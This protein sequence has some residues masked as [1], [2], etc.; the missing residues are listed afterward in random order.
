M[1]SAMDLTWIDQSI[2]AKSDV[3]KADLRLSLLTAST[4]I[5]ALQAGQ[6]DRAP[7]LHTHATSDVADLE[8][9]LA[10]RVRL[11]GGEAANLLLKGATQLGLG[12][13]TLTAGVLTLDLTDGAI[14]AQQ[15]TSNVTSIAI[16]N[17][18]A[19]TGALSIKLILAQDNAGSRTVTWPANWQGIG[20]DAVTQ[21]ATAGN[22]R[23]IYEVWSYDNGGT[24][25]VERQVT[26]F[27][28][29]SPPVTTLDGD[30]AYGGLW[31]GNAFGG[32]GA[33]GNKTV[34]YSSTGWGFVAATI[35]VY[36]TGN[37]THIRVNNRTDRAGESGYGNGQCT[38]WLEI[39][40]ALADG[41]PD[42]TSGGLLG[43]TNNYTPET[44]NGPHLSDANFHPKLAFQANVPVTAGAKICVVWKGSTT[45]NS[46]FYSAN[47]LI[48]DKPITPRAGPAWGDCKVWTSSNGGDTWSEAK[49]GGDT[50][51]SRG[52]YCF[53]GDFFYSDGIVHG[54][55][56]RYVNSSAATY[57]PLIDGGSFVRQRFQM[58]ANSFTTK[59]VWVRLFSEA[60]S[61][62]LTVTLQ[63]STGTVIEAIPVPASLVT[64]MTSGDNVVSKLLGNPRGKPNAGTAAAIQ[65]FRLPFSTN[66]TLAG[67]A[68]YEVR[69][70]G[71]AG[72]KGRINGLQS[73]RR[74]GLYNSIEG[75]DGP[76]SAT[77]AEY[78]TNNGGTWSKV[79]SDSGN[80]AH[81]LPIVFEAA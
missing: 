43:R 16:E 14:F 64:K 67:G 49:R 54:N 46:K 33:I 4:E 20:G 35:P 38:A 59:A 22:S 44:V 21:P 36:K 15:L 2:A 66:R 9:A 28:A 3:D 68:L 11:T 69:I 58:R 63:T 61:P 10:D 79:V 72:S 81:D 48:N 53:W 71:T 19:T 1:T 32:A 30:L 25:T 13:S 73:G 8:D 7:L 26:G 37:L 57:I 47:F 18:P 60:E 23:S 80:G 70:T 40:K 74:E 52:A 29:P 27:A 50:E 31:Y 55:P 12:Q 5:S 45:D 62:A 65:W 17:L 39:R 78:T 34:R 77:V 24:W 75:F 56:Y 6:A 41:K 51:P 76:A 42:M